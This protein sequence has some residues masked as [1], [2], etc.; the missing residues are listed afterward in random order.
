MESVR[1]GEVKKERIKSL[2]KERVRR[3]EKMKEGG[4]GEREESRKMKK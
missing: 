4:K 3:I 2:A 1:T